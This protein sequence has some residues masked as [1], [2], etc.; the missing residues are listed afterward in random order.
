MAWSFSSSIFRISFSISALALAPSAFPAPT[1]RG[2]VSAK[3][4]RTSANRI[5]VPFERKVLVAAQRNSFASFIA[6]QRRLVSHKAPLTV[7]LYVYACKASGNAVNASVV[8]HHGTSDARHDGSASINVETVV[9]LKKRLVFNTT[10]V[11]FLEPVLFCQDLS[12]RIDEDQ[13]VTIDPFENLDV[14]LLHGIVLQGLYCEDF[15]FDGKVLCGVGLRLSSQQ[16][17]PSSRGKR[18]ENQASQMFY[19]RVPSLA[20]NGILR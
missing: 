2:V 3:R 8:I 20:H 14:S 4:K 1:I 15:F 13:T 5:V 10:R 19:A 17:G 7:E 18:Q 11:E 6:R 9:A 16:R 12:S